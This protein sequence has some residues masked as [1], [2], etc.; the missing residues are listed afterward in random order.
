MVTFFEVKDVK[1]VKV[2]SN[3]SQSKVSDAERSLFHIT[4]SIYQLERREEK[5]SGEVKRLRSEVLVKLKEGNRPAATLLL[6]RAKMYES[7]LSKAMQSRDTLLQISASIEEAQTSSAVFEAMKMG[8]ETLK[9]EN[10]KLGSVDTVEALLDDVS[11]LIQETNDISDAVM[12][13]QQQLLSGSIDES[14]LEKEL[15]ELA[16]E[17]L[18]DLKLS[19][20]VKPTP[21]IAR[22]GPDTTNATVNAPASASS[23]SLDSLVSELELL[24]V[25]TAPIASSSTSSSALKY[26]E[27]DRDPQG[28]AEPV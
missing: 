14:E 6:K 18:R 11:E 20:P 9:S 13:S 17:E 12:G 19:K 26:G 27:Q 15:A 3:P 24:S 7:H 23:S 8:A 21:T 28:Q 10:A 2:A 1:G 16:K 5:Y 22:A 25:P 4:N